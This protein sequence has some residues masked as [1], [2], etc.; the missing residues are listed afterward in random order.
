MT[1]KKIGQIV[2]IS[3]KKIGYGIFFIALSVG[4]MLAK[5]SYIQPEEKFL[6]SVMR[7]GSYGQYGEVDISTFVKLLEN[8]EMD[9]GEN[10]Q[11]LGWTQKDN[12]YTLHIVMKEPIDIKIT[13]LLQSMYNG[14]YS[15]L[16]SIEPDNIRADTFLLQI[17]SLVPDNVINK[18]NAE[19]YLKEHPTKTG[20]CVTDT[21]AKDFPHYSGNVHAILKK[22]QAVSVVQEEVKVSVA[23]NCGENC[24]ESKNSWLKIVL[25]DTEQELKLLYVKKSDIRFSDNQ[26]DDTDSVS[27]NVDDGF[28]GQET[29]S[30]SGA[31]EDTATIVTND[32]VYSPSKN[33]FMTSSIKAQSSINDAKHKIENIMSG[34]E[35]VVI[36]ISADKN[37]YKIQAKGKN[38]ILYVPVDSVAIF[39]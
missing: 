33:G 16:T 25:F 28:V 22:G 21:E 12:E 26:R 4:V 2:K 24:G 32:I 39:D 36:G 8:V 19:N 34:S 31:I 18:I 37:Y 20:Y 5:T 11:I 1:I 23:G 38:T 6:N 14:K 29:A 35:V 7:F 17:R 30:Q 10:P 13:Y 9:N 27:I 3:K 15:V